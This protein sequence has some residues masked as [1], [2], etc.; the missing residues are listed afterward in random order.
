MIGSVSVRLP[1]GAF[2]RIVGWLTLLARARAS[3]EVETLVLRHENAVLQRGNPRPRLDW[4]D[5]AVLTALIRHLP[6]V[7]AAACRL[8]TPTTVLALHGR[9]VAKRWTFPNQIGGM[10]PKRGR[11]VRT[12]RF[13]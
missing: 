9:L 10:L 13:I 12:V 4:A 6:Q 5:R 7:G 1:Y 2:C 8:V 11:P 3:L